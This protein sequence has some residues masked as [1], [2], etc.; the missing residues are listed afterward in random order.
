[1]GIS[2]DRFVEPVDE[3][4]ICS[5]CRDVLDN[6]VTLRLCDHHFCRD[7]ITQYVNT[8][9]ICPVCRGHLCI[10]DIHSV[11]RPFNNLLIKQKLHCRYHSRGCEF[12]STV[13]GIP[14]HEKH[15]CEYT[16]T[17]C[18][19]EGCPHYTNGKNGD[20]SIAISQKDFFVHT[21]QCEWKL[22]LCLLGCGARVK[23]NQIA[24]HKETC[25]AIIEK[26]H[27]CGTQVKRKDLSTHE[28]EECLLCQ[29]KCDVFGC[30]FAAIRGDST[31]WEQ[32]EKDA[33]IL[34]TRLINKQLKA[35]K[36]ELKV[37]TDELK[38][39]NKKL[40]LAEDEL[41][42]VWKVAL[43]V[44]EVT[45]MVWV[46]DNIAENRAANATITSDDMK[47]AHPFVTRRYTF[48]LK[49]RFS[50]EGMS[51]GFI[52]R[53]GNED[54]VDFLNWPFEDLIQL[55]VMNHTSQEH[56]EKIIGES[57]EHVDY[58][59]DHSP[60]DANNEDGCWEL[61]LSNDQIADREFLIYDKIVV[62]VTLLDN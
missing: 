8:T 56:E 24:S 58:F 32:H 10:S 22:V 34:H 50:S 47:F 9:K 2:S 57:D 61:F 42:S 7:C 37:A 16:P 38:T 20:E 62:V 52:L 19:N 5:I 18:P 29:A 12:I 46:V 44:T 30:D 48:R 4:F 15:E 17:W 25:D 36:H 23:E 3:E 54:E 53:R 60:P 45:S 28:A 27:A 41:K 55:Q 49:M 26:C 40:K 51:L 11:S 39:T 14:S 1:M 13:E 21:L 6:P 31:T 33:S 35:T 43:D 59:S